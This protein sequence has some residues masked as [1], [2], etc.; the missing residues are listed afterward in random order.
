MELKQLAG[1]LPY[2]LKMYYALSDD[3]WILDIDNIDCITK[4]DKP[5]LR[6]LSDLTKEIY[7][8]LSTYVFTGL[9]EIGDYDGCIFEFEHG[10]IKTIKLLEYISKNNSHSD[11]DYLPHAVVS[12]MYEHHFDIH[13]LI[14]KGEAIDINTLPNVNQSN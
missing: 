12:M 14:E 11:I 4:H 8:G 10:N 7:Y 2:G 6:P 3:T 5:I 1:Y 13:G 9:F